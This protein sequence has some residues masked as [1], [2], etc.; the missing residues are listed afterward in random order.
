MYELAA[1]TEGELVVATPRG[2]PGNGIPGGYILPFDFARLVR[3]HFTTGYVNQV[4]SLFLDPPDPPTTIHPSIWRLT[5]TGDGQFYPMRPMDL[6]GQPFDT[7]QRSWLADEP[8]YHLAHGPHYHVTGSEGSVIEHQWINSTIIQ[9]LPLPDVR[10]A[11]QVFYVPKAHLLIDDT[12]HFAYD[13][14][15]WIILDC[16]AQCLEKQESDS[17]PL[18]ARLEQVKNR[19]LNNART[20]DAANPKM[21]SMSSS[22]HVQ[23]GQNRRRGPPWS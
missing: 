17:R 6:S 13:F 5:T 16:A 14:P 1:G 12:A 18:R 10:Y 3:V 2:S 8:K 4:N 23:V 20:V 22:H 19:I 11:V 7:K 21:I 15:E 9:F